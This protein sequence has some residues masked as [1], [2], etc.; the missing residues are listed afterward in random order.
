MAWSR[1]WERV[2]TRFQRCA[3]SRRLFAAWHVAACAR[4]SFLASSH[5]LKMVHVSFQ[6]AELGRDY[7]C[8]DAKRIFRQPSRKKGAPP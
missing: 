7:L 1:T 6:G 2:V 3:H 4:L 5:P 8:R